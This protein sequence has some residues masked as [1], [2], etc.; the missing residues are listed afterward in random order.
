MKKIIC[1]FILIA[2]ISFQA[3]AQ[4][5]IAKMSKEICKCIEDPKNTGSKTTT[6]QTCI[7]NSIVGHYADISKELKIDMTDESNGEKIGLLIAEDL[8]KTCPNFLAYAM[9]MSE[10]ETSA[11]S[12]APGTEVKILDTLTADTKY[13]SVFKKGK[14]KYVNS[15]YVNN[16]A[17][18][19]TDASA[20]FTM[21]ADLMT[22]YSENGKYVTKTKITWKSDCGY[23]A[24]LVESN[25]PNVNA[26]IKPGDVITGRVH[27]ASANG[28][29]I[30]LVQSFKGIEIINEVSKVE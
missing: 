1:L 12:S 25:N 17:I 23:E 7:T 8:I 11:N 27:Y 18:P 29:K 3:D 26:V 15:T 9:A 19:S 21:N 30:Y 10:E 6:F 2:G 24:K 14:F 5:V 16:K 13:C 20:Y 28:K 4:K 22:D